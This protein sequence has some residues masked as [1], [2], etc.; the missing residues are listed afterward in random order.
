MELLKLKMAT[1][2]VLLVAVAGC[3][4]SVDRDVANATTT[5]ETVQVNENGEVTAATD[6][7]KLVCYHEK[8]IGSNRKTTRCMSKADRDKMREVSR[9]AW[10]RQQQGS[11]TG[12]G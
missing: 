3:S 8:K 4:A 6:E 12:G 9:E 5:E 10:L 2:A 11:E 1:M 7:S